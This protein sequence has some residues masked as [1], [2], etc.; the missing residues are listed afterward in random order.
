[1]PDEVGGPPPVA[2]LTPDEA[3]AYLTVMDETQ[4]IRQTAPADR[5]VLGEAEAR[6]YIHGDLAEPSADAPKLIDERTSCTSQVYTASGK[7]EPTLWDCGSGANLVDVDVVSKMVEGDDYE[8]L[9]VVPPDLVGLGNKQV[10][11]ARA[12]LLHLRCYPNGPLVSFPA[13]V[14]ELRNFGVSLFIGRP[15]LR[16]LRAKI[17]F[18]T[19]EQD[20]VILDCGEGGCSHHIKAVPG[21]PRPKVAIQVK[22]RLV[23][24]PGQPRQLPATSQGSAALPIGWLAAKHGREKQPVMVAVIAEAMR[25]LFAHNETVAAAV[26]AA[27]TVAASTGTG[28]VDYNGY[29][30]DRQLKE[31]A[32]AEKAAA[33]LSDLAAPTQHPTWEDCV[34]KAA[35]LPDPAQREAGAQLL[36]KWR[37]RFYMGGGLPAMRGYAFDV[38]AKE[39]APGFLHKP[40]PLRPQHLGLA[41]ELVRSWVKAGHASYLT[42]SERAVAHRASRAFFKEE[43][44]KLRMCVDY[45][46][47]SSQSMLMAMVMPNADAI[48]KSLAGCD[49]YF[50]ADVRAAFNQIMLTERAQMFM[51]I[52]LPGERPMDPPIYIKP[53]R[54][55][56]G[57]LNSPAYF[58]SVMDELLTG[59]PAEHERLSPYIDDVNGGV[60]GSFEDALALFVKML[61]ATEKSGM[62]FSWEK[63]QFMVRELRILGF[64]V[65]KDGITPDP[66]RVDDIRNWPVPRTNRDVQG[67]LGLWV[68]LCKHAP[69]ATNAAVRLLQTVGTKPP[70]RWTKELQDAFDVVK[71]ITCQ[72]VLTAPLDLA[73]RVYIQSDSSK[74]AMGWCISQVDPETEIRRVVALGSRAWPEAARRYPSHELET[75]ALL[76]E[77]R[78]R[79]TEFIA[80]PITLETDNEATAMLLTSTPFSQLTAKYQRY[81]VMLQEFSSVQVEYVGAKRVVL[82][83]ILSRQAKW[84]R[85]S[86]QLLEVAAA[87][88]GYTA[89]D[90]ELAAAFVVGDYPV[91]MVLASTT[92]TSA[93]MVLAGTTSNTAEPELLEQLR[94]AQAACP[95]CQKFAAEPTKA[96][97]DLKPGESVLYVGDDEDR[98]PG[99]IQR[100]TADGATIVTQVMCPTAM[101]AHVLAETHN[102]THPGST[103]TYKNLRRTWWWPN[104]QRDTNEWV[105]RCEECTLSKARARTMEVGHFRS[106]PISALFETLSADV[107]ELS[108]PSYGYRHILVVQDTY[109]TFILLVPLKTQQSEEIAW[110]LIERVV[111]Y[112]GPPDQ[113]ITDRGP[114]FASALTERVL[115]SLKVKRT[116]LFAHHAQ[117]NGQNERSHGPIMTSLRIMCAGYKESWARALPLIQYEYNITP[118][119]GSSLSAYDIVFARQPRPLGTA[120]LPPMAQHGAQVEDLA[121]LD[122]KLMAKSLRETWQRLRQD[123]LDRR[124]KERAAVPVAFEPGDKVVVVYPPDAKRR[125]KHYFPGEGPYV[126]ESRQNNDYTIRHLTTQHVKT[127]HWAVLHRYLERKPTAAPSGNGAGRGTAV[128]GKDAM[129]VDAQEQERDGAQAPGATAPGAAASKRKKP[130]RVP[131]N[132]GELRPA[133]RVRLYQVDDRGQRLPFSAPIESD[134][135]DDGAQAPGAAAPSATAPHQAQTSARA[136]SLESA[137]QYDK[138]LAA[139]QAKPGLT[140]PLA[141]DDYVIVARGPDQPGELAIGQLRDVADTHVTV[142]WH[143]CPDASLPTPQQA[144]WPLYRNNKGE[145]TPSQLPL[146]RQKA[147]IYEVDRDRVLYTF[148]ALTN[149]SR[150]PHDVVQFLDKM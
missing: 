149:E 127:V 82:C 38:A 61:E 105:A 54:M 123:N 32:L 57:Y 83:D 94:A 90:I 23:G 62:L 77:L 118:R 115:D 8:E 40:I 87:H 37:H 12:V 55:G 49:W 93:V 125:S 44:K 2:V 99:V 31:R 27:C 42:Q 148:P 67:F 34:A 98:Y 114:A 128:L 43:K 22:N 15:G 142:H 18:D 113:L 24:P 3:R 81:R 13:I 103:A 84:Y 68:Y 33:T 85:P 59:V 28:N 124:E 140:L 60:K 150:L 51:V 97:A 14:A 64:Y 122:I 26:A 108:I 135:D 35:H 63:L 116:L 19:S 144:W 10:S 137:E 117:A 121:E 86:S 136:R 100:R 102:T 5:L 66:E 138:M 95:D 80:T 131:G 88:F 72:Y 73:R 110:A 79:R 65:S 36:F 9:D 1:M 143:D 89:R 21:D 16:Q 106:R 141:E 75:G 4:A 109:S 134:D 145:L 39:N 30:T 7:E 147:E 50:S 46:T 6:A 52:V 126:V 53:H 119:A 58:Q 17:D 132:T 69:Q 96:P 91:V 29:D 129:E 130:A 41:H 76:F 74:D 146:L 107:L 70:F 47:L 20:V 120:L 133:K 111:A 104:M 71:A 25:M 56:F 112:F 92:A 45:S 101:R 78:R 11:T 139:R 48:R